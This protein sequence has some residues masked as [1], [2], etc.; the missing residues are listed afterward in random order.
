MRNL[1]RNSGLGLTTN[2][3]LVIVGGPYPV[4]SFV[5]VPAP[6]S[7]VAGFIV[8][9]GPGGLAPGKLVAIMGPN[10]HAFS[11]SGLNIESGS[12]IS[13]AP[14][15]TF[16]Q[17]IGDL[18]WVKGGSNHSPRTQYRV[19]SVGGDGGSIALSGG[20]KNET[21]V[22]FD[23]VAIQGGYA[24]DPSVN[25]MP[26]AGNPLAACFYYPLQVTVTGGNVFYAT[27]AGHDLSC[28]PSSTATAWEVTNGDQ[29]T[30]NQFGPDW[31]SKTPGLSFYKMRGLDWDG[32]TVTGKPGE[33]YSVKLVKTSPAQECFWQDLTASGPATVDT[34]NPE[35]LARFKGKKVAC[36]AYLSGP[37]RLYIDD[38]VT[39]TYSSAGVGYQWLEV[40]VTI[41]TNA[42]KAQVG[43]ALDG[44]VGDTFLLTQPMAVRGTSI[45]EGNY[46]ASTPA[47]QMFLSHVNPFYY[48]GRPVPSGA[49][50]H[51][52]QETCG[53]IPS[54][55]QSI[56][57]DVEGLHA[58]GGAWLILADAP[59]YPQ[60]SALT[61]YPNPGSPAKAVNTMSVGVGRALAA[62]AGNFYSDVHY[63]NVA[64]A[65]WTIN[66][67]Y[68]GGVY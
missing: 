44:A 5:T 40:S 30:S 15:G 65:G 29:G 37:G 48:L 63:I 54:G 56:Q 45:G 6:G 35:G 51:L 42:T 9:G 67:D 33:L 27:M 46:E 62:D 22:S 52:E 23:F 53:L 66:I 28:G 50:I 1:L 60:M 10:T 59:A 61:L 8:P 25:G 34:P 43:V 55:M 39:R 13:N 38:G 18:L 7:N 12:I 36:G 14:L 58:P 47:F 64:D 31:W 11:A 20:L 3:S 26:R 16:T 4:T 19:T 57:S 32:V 17:A 24:I 68:L 2:H 49:Y 21:G 41:S